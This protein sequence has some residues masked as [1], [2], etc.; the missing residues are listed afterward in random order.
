MDL[1]AD[2]GE[3]YLWVDSA[4]IIQDDAVDKRRELSMMGEIYNHATLVIV[5]A[6]ENAHSGLP[7]RGQHKHQWNRPTEDIRGLLFTT[8]Q[9]EL[10]HKFD[11]TIWNT[12]GWTFQEGYLARRAIT[13]TEH[14]VY[15]NCREETWSEGRLT[16]F[17]NLRHVAFSHNSLF[18]LE[19]RKAI[20]LRL[21]PQS[22]TCPLWEYR[23]KVQTFSMRSFS[24]HD[25]TPWAF[26]DVLK[27][28]L[29]KFPKGYLWGFPN[30]CLDAALLWE[31]DCTCKHR[32]PSV[33]PSEKREWQEWMIPSWCWVSKGSKVWYDS[34]GSSVKSM[35]DWHEPVQDEEYS[36]PTD[37]R[38]CERKREEHLRSLIFPAE[39]DLKKATK[40]AFAQLHFTAQTTVLRIHTPVKLGE[41]KAPGCYIGLATVSLLS[42]KDI[43][44]IK[45]P[46]LAMNSELDMQ[47]EFVLLSS[48]A[49][50]C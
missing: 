13:L 43:G 4:C 38:G 10:H 47:G 41:I 37:C 22:F 24:R 20:D 33:I 49:D 16:E 18:S 15:W 2:L 28:L 21:S 32:A 23:Q 29:P 9:P 45:I 42:G 14:Q 5:A 25:D 35:V 31:T 6:V 46:I 34:C 30:D 19:R 8:G 48:K 39:Q 11:T 50:D 44:F 17:E 36:P 12:R 3:R 26:F 1:V 7:G 40:F 27:S